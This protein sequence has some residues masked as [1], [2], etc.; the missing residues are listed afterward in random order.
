MKIEDQVVSLELAKKLKELGVKQE[1]LFVWE[2]PN[3]EWGWTDWLVVPTSEQHDLEHYPAYT[4]AELGEM[5]APNIEQDS[6][7]KPHVTGFDNN[8]E[9]YT[10]LE[11]NAENEAEIIADTEADARAKMLIYLLE[12]N[13]CTNP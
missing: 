13:L 1:S 9:W 12:N 10:Y 11:D 5:L 8:I 2:A 7:P 4:V 3:T 6:I